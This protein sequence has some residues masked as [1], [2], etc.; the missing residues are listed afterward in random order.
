MK[1]CWLKLRKTLPYFFPFWWCGVWLYRYLFVFIN[2]IYLWVCVCIRICC[3]LVKKGLKA[4]KR[5]GESE[6]TPAGNKHVTR[7]FLSLHAAEAH[8]C[9][10]SAINIQWV[11]EYFKFITLNLVFW[12]L[13]IF[14]VTA[15]LPPLYIHRPRPNSPFLDQVWRSLSVHKRG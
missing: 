7:F 9:Q 13:Y 10:R 6:N 5:E 3:V 4:W 8:K 12:G 1:D 11:V 15:C 2:N 14:H